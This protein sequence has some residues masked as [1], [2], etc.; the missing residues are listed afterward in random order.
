MLN[1]ESLKQNWQKI[2]SGL[3]EKFSQ[4]TDTDLNFEYRDLDDLIN[5]LRTRLGK[6]RIEIH[7][8]L[9]SINKKIR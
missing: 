9:E 2:S 6:T 8:M 7:E 3:K 5:K 1:F 4:L